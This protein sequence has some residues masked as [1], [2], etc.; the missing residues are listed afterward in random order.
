M[1]TRMT[2]ADDDHAGRAK[3]VQV[4]LTGLI[5]TAEAARKTSVGRKKARGRNAGSGRTLLSESGP[6]AMRSVCAR[7]RS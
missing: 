3:A 4:L 6:I 7:L 2:V 5:Q 1:F